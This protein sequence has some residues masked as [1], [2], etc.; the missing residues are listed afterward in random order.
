LT[1]FKDFIEGVLY[2]IK[3]KV[4]KGIQILSDL[5]EI[6]VN[7]NLKKSDDEAA[8]KDKKKS[9]ASRS[10]SITSTNKNW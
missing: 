10:A 5:L 4:K 8:K 3:R 7:S 6:L 2:L 9:L 1:L